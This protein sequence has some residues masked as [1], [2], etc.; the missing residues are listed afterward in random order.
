ML[1]QVHKLT[2][3][4]IIADFGS[5]HIR[6]DASSP[7]VP[8][9]VIKPHTRKAQLTEYITLSGPP[10]LL[11]TIREDAG[12]NLYRAHMYQL[13][14]WIDRHVVLEEQAWTW[15]MHYYRAIGLDIDDL[16]P[17]TTYKQYQR[18]TVRKNSKKYLYNQENDV[19]KNT[20][21]LRGALP[22][23]ME[24]TSRLI[25]SLP[26]LFYNRAGSPD[27][28][29]IR[30]AIMYGMHHMHD[31]CQADIASAFGM[32]Q[33]AVSEHIRSFKAILH[34]HLPSLVTPSTALLTAPSL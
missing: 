1:L 15:M 22:E 32:T 23:V 26:E 31:W 3:L 9:L 8:W 10:D 19:L 33:Q 4:T 21:P 34:R 14:Q 20:S 30:K 7:L 27:A 11:S 13:V 18:H 25:S 6:V 2:R 28:S 16:A 5:D 12:F 24:S 29:M 17:E